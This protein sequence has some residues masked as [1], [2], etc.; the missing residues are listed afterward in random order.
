MKSIE[1]NGCRLNVQIDISHEDAP[2]I[3]F[4]NS[5]LTDLSI[6]D[7][8][9]AVLK[10]QFN[11]LRYDQRGHGKSDVSNEV[12]SFEILAD[13]LIKL[14]DH[15]NIPKA[16]YVGLSMG[17]PTG[18]AAYNQ[19]RFEKMVFI[20]GQT[21]SASN[22]S[23]A[24]QERI[25]FAVAHGIEKL[26]ELTSERW[27]T[28]LEKKSILASMMASTPL[29]GFVSAATALKNYDFSPLLSSIHCPVLLI[30]G[31]QD[32]KMPITMQEMAKN[33]VYASYIEIENAGHVPCFEQSERVNQH[34]ISFLE[35]P[36]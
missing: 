27:L 21:K 17:V 4:A 26:A 32:G 28:S 24:W 7:A 19:Q 8:Q 16:I 2:W 25:D 1:V 23:E 22:A 36:I 11:L 33:M 5:L 9:I 6:W 18:L 12:L 10:N 29:Q 13:D 31:A 3:V 30:A 15:F 35:V 34:L 14:M 20:D